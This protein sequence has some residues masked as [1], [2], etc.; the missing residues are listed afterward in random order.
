MLIAVY[1]FGCFSKQVM[2][3]YSYISNAD[4]GYLDQLYQNYKQDPASVDATWQKFFEGYD[5]SSQRYGE[6]GR[7][8]WAFESK[9]QPSARA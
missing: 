9:H 5:F 8:F 2:D 3:K 6:N 7:V 1:T 4:S